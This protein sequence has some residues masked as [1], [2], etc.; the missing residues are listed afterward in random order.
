M[1]N[2]FSSTKEYV[3]SEE[4]MAAVNVAIALKKTSSY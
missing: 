4:L 1:D 3:A 2:N